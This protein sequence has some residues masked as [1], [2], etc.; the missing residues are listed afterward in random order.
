MWLFGSSAKLAK[1][2][3]EDA[4]YEQAAREVENGRMQQGTLA[5]ARAE[6]QGDEQKANALYLQRRAEDIALEANAEREAEM[7]AQ[8]IGALE[9]R[10]L[11]KAA[12]REAEA[13]AQ[14]SPKN[15][16]GALTVVVIVGALM[17]WA[18]F[19]NSPMQ[20]S[21]TSTGVTDSKPPSTQTPAQQ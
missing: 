12:K 3:R 14:Q 17:I 16:G 4:N 21:S 8:F 13:K 10:R 20:E 9:D 2:K 7:K 11:A 19:H 1:R 5:K 15:G 18:Y 6:A